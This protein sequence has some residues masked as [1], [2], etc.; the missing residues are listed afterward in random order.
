MSRYAIR[1]EVVPRQDVDQIRQLITDVLADHAKEFEVGHAV[2][3]LS[4]KTRTIP[5][6]EADR[7]A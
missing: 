5:V 3:I 4:G 2:L 1:I 7:G 6:K